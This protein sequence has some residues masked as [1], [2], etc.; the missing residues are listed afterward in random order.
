MQS[1]VALLIMYMTEEEAFCVLASFADDIR[2]QMEHL[3]R[4]NMPAIKLRFYQT[5]RLVPAF[6]PKLSK[7]FNKC[8][9]MVQQNGLLQ[10]F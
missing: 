2:C 5:E 8:D 9:I 1:V 6:L 7:H 3:W 4:G 10:V